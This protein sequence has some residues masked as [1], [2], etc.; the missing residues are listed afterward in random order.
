MDKKYDKYLE[1]NYDND[2][3]EKQEK[4]DKLQAERIGKLVDNMRRE[5]TEDLINSVLGDEELP[6]GDEEAVRE[7]LHE[8]VSNKDELSCGRGSAYLQ[9][10][11]YRHLFDW[12]CGTWNRDKKY[13][14]PNTNPPACFQQSF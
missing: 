3:K 13:K 6:I 10:G 8:Y 11:I 1:G 4:A 7:L 9:Y 2:N 12:K 5:Q 14:K